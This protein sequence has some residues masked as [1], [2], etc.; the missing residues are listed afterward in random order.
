[1]SDKKT[2]FTVRIDDDLLN[3]FKR[4]CEQNDYTLAFVI[5]EL[6]KNYINSSEK[7]QDLFNRPIQSE[8]S[9]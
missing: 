9:V 1:M 7:Q 2:A 3:N 6:M 5:R 8:K 4:V